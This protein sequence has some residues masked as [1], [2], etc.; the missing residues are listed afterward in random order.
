[1]TLNYQDGIVLSFLL[2]TDDDGSY[3]FTI[4]PNNPIDIAQLVLRLN[5]FD[6]VNKAEIDAVMLEIKLEVEEYEE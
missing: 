5:E 6:C 2:K 1:M 3:I 4:N